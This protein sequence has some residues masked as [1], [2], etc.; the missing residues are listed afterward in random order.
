MNKTLRNYQVDGIATIKA[1]KNF[2]LFWQQ[3]MGKTPVAIKAVENYD[4]VVF[5]VPN[6]LLYH[7]R[8]EISKWSE[9]TAT[10]IEGSKAKRDKSYLDFKTNTNMWI[11]VSY[12]NLAQDFLKDNTLFRNF[13]YLVVDE[14]HFLRNHKTKRSKGIYAIRNNATHALALTGT[15]AV[16]SSID[17]LKI[18]KLID[19]TRNFGRR[20]Q[21]KKSYFYN[22]I[23]ET[24]PEIKKVWKVR[25]ERLDKWNLLV[26]ELCDIKKVRD[27]L[28]WIPLTTYKTIELNMASSQRKAYNKMLIEA[29]RTIMNTAKEK[30]EGTIFAQIMRLQQITLEPLLIDVDATS[31]KT[32]W[33]IEYLTYV[34]ENTDE[35]VIVFSK[36][37][38]YLKQFNFK[39][40]N[41]L[42]FLTGKENAK[43]KQDVI[44]TFQ[45]KKT[46][47]IMANLQV[48][49]LG[50]T[51]DAATIAVFMDKSWNPVD[52]EQASFRIVDTVKDQIH[53]PK[54]IINVICHNS[55]DQRIQRVLDDKHNKTSFIYELRNYLLEDD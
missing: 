2:G 42:S 15:P 3:R 14:A 46:R 36:F 31:V 35:Q 20:Y 6:G 43:Q 9:Q 37:T 25:P 4:K 44:N 54:L 53:Q 18:F 23:I 13:D 29:R 55:I 33:L 40:Q 49:S 16:S 26:N 50:Y 7:W 12:D 45:N 8:H 39:Y 30:Q 1:K 11:I 17:I 34:I 24:E 22:K 47:I 32:N 48:A 52:N 41:E 27:Y 28:Q 21:Y 19:P 10:V 51:L 5:A 38:S